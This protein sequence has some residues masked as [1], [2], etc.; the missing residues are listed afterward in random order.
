MIELFT[1]GMIML[2]VVC[3]IVELIDEGITSG[4]F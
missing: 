2:F 4:L 1:Y 3:L